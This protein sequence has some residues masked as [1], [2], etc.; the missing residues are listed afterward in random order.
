MSRSRHYWRKIVAV[1][2]IVAMSTGLA[3]ARAQGAA[4]TS[5][6]AGNQLYVMP[7]NSAQRAMAADP[8]LPSA[9]N[10]I[11]GQPT[12][13]WIV[14]QNPDTQNRAYVNNIETAA[15]AAGRIPVFVLYAITNR[16]CG[17]HSSG[18]EPTATAYGALVDNVKMGIAGRK[19]VVIVEPDAIVAAP[20]CLTSAQINERGAL[21]RYAVTT[22]AVPGTSVYLDAGNWNSK[23]TSDQSA[24]YL[25]AALPAVAIDR[26]TGFA[27][28]T[29]AMLTTAD[30]QAFGDK[31]SAQLAAAG[32]PGKRY[33]IDTSRNGNG[34]GPNTSGYCNLRGLALGADPTTSTGHAMNDAFLWV[35]FPGESDGACSG[36]GTPDANAPASGVFW[37]AYAMM[38]INNRATLRA[39]G[40]VTS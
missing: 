39:G 21:L 18:G 3:G 38:L 9:L 17:L 20:T 28:D 8:S 25:M 10:Q 31:V 5:S 7:N 40:K 24:A 15:T 37:P 29:S 30:E 11:A 14:P 22:L 33:V 35:K 4:V 2:A 1:V 26:A 27:L 23:G 19:A 16:D 13:Y 34:T 36:N 32:Y 6:L 12:S